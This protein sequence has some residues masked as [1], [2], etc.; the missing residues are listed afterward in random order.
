[1][2]QAGAESKAGAEIATVPTE[3]S[4]KRI[5]KRKT[6]QQKQE[7]RDHDHKDSSSCRRIKILEA[8]KQ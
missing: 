3:E 1:M 7:P 2:R 6:Q 4:L 8:D 5:T